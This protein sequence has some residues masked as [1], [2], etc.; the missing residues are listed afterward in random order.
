VCSA[1]CCEY[2]DDP[3]EAHATG[4]LCAH[5]VQC[6]DTTCNKWRKVPTRD[7]AK[8]QNA[9]VLASKGRAGC[10]YTCLDCV[11]KCDGC[12]AAVCECN[13]VAV[14]KKKANKKHRV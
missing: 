5:W 2:E 11:L 12:L 7:F 1:Q 6:D 14:D 8:R 10:Q 13:G 4:R 9:A 3:K